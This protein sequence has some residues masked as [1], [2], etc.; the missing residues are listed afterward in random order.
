MMKLPAMEAEELM[1]VMQCALTA[2]DRALSSEQWRVISQ[3]IYNNRNPLFMK[4]VCLSPHLLL[5]EPNEAELTIIF[6]HCCIQLF[7]EAVLWTS[8]SMVTDVSALYMEAILKL[9]SR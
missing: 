1:G 8:Y 9:F 2:C 6:V 3:R 4:L 7:C 5:S